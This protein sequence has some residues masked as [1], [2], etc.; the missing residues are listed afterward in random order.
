MSNQVQ[1]EAEG[2]SCSVA[3]V[4]V[5]DPQ[6]VVD[7]PCGYA[8]HLVGVGTG[9]EDPSVGFAEYEA[10][11]VGQR[12]MACQGLRCVVVALFLLT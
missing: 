10:V 2:P 9:E 8:A 1:D 7:S 11:L 6:V 12:G 5:G 4:L 3:L